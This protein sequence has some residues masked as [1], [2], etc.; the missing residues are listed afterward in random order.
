MLA[1]SGAGVLLSQERLLRSLPPH[2]ARVVCL[3]GGGD[4]EVADGA[5]EAEGAG[6]GGE[7]GVA[8]KVRG[9][10]S[11]VGDTGEADAGGSDN[12]TEADGAGGA[13]R[14]AAAGGGAAAAATAE[15]LAY[16]IYTSGSAG[17]PKGVGVP[18]GALVNFLAAMCEEPGLTAADR[19]LAVTSLSFDIAGLELWLPLFAGAEI[20]LISREVAAD[21]ARLLARL[22]AAAGEVADSGGGAAVRIGA[23]DA[24]ASAGTAGTV[25]LQATPSTW[26]LLLAAGWRGG[27]GIRA[28]CG[29]EALPPALAAEVGAR[30]GALW[31]V[32]GPT[33]TTIWSAV[34]RLDAAAAA[35]PGGSVPLGHPIANTTIHLVDPRFSAV[36]LGVP[37]ELL[38][39]GAGLARGYL[40]RP[41]LTAER[42]VPDPFAGD[43]GGGAR[44]YR[45]GDLARSTPEGEIEFLGRIDHQVK[46]RGQRI[47][48]GEIE[49]VVG[50]HPAV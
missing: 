5:G 16:V 40:F 31:N 13:T 12:E 39:G 7:V 49:A 48:L 3:D 4:E 26:R 10:E 21:G 19:L 11:V 41:E 6:R 8:G 33:E 38:V 47:E 22:S 32:Y 15:N 1:D 25:M 44:L 14:V 34:H 36:P 28:L 20:D 35:G 42:F 24:W 2:E 18:H 17:R 27:E 50:R 29:G 43:S 46:I 37:G 9:S 45:T 23:A 30:A